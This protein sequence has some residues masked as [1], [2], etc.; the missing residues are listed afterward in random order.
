MDLLVYYDG[1]WGTFF[2]GFPYKCFQVRRNLVYENIGHQLIFIILKD[3]W[4]NLITILVS[5]T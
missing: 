1:F 3:F 5:H 4:A 2:Y